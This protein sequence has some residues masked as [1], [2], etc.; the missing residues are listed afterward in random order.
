MTLTPAG[1]ESLV[2]PA[3]IGIYLDNSATTRPDP[4]VI[5]AVRRALEVEYGNPSSVHRLGTAARRL[6][7][8]SRRAVAE[9]LGVAP[10][11]I[12]FTS[13]ATEANNLAIFGLARQWRSHRPPK[14]LGRPHAITTAV[15][16]PSVLEP[17]RRLQEEG[18]EVTFLPVNRHGQLDPEHLSDALRP[19]TVF[20]STMWVNNETGVIM[21]LSAI[22]ERLNRWQERFGRR[23]LWHVDAVQAVGKLPTR[24]RDLGIDLLSLSGHK[25]HGPKGV[26]ALYVRRGVQLSP[27]L[28]GG[29]QEGGVRS[30]TENIP[31]IAGLGAACQ[32]AA[33]RL[34]GD[35]EGLHLR[36]LRD[37][38]WRLIEERIPG[39]IRHGPTA[40]DMSAPH[41]LNVSFP[42]TKGEVLVRYLSERGV[43]VATG[44]ACHSRRP[45]PSHVL[46]A[47]GLSLDEVGSSIR[48][49][50]S[51]ENAE[52][53]IVQA[54]AIL[55]E[56]VAEIRELTGWKPGRSTDL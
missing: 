29:G 49:S 6:L 4:T 31:G 15:E 18:W 7:D 53:E 2:R 42:G 13:G 56:V 50:L 34:A 45:E 22:Y 3:E 21:P 27:M 30:G 38:L 52:E 39:V 20:I 19:E 23:P 47:M 51:W 11:E 12:I 9:L 35:P 32:L 8:E 36:K 5:E 10:E 26:G 46:T 55:K 14:D 54:A 43:F 33:R 41:I 40:P 48:F 1:V 44:S 37:T 28:L 25:M 24:P 17:F 16:H